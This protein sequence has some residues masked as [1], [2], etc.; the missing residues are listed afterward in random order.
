[1]SA[2]PSFEALDQAWA[3]MKRHPRLAL[4]ELDFKNGYFEE[5]EAYK[6]RVHANARAS[7]NSP[8]WRENMVGTGEIYQAAANAIKT[9]ENNLVYWEKRNDFS[10]E[11]KGLASKIEKA[12]W[13]IYKGGDSQESLKAGYDQLVEITDYQTTAFFFFL[14]EQ[15]QYLPISQDVFDRAFSFLGLDFKTSFNASWENYRHF[16]AI[17]KQV[18]AWLHERKAVTNRSALQDAHSFLYWL[19]VLVRDGHTKSFPE[20]ASSTAPSS[21]S[22]QEPQ[23]NE[24]ELPLFPPVG[25][26]DGTDDLD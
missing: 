19:G 15:N 21:T 26:T 8:R 4:A 12:L 23:P 14:K 24:T 16:I 6:Y 5:Q 2:L 20:V 11:Y 18:K 22:S 9:P 13:L 25:T 10:V 3:Y 17:H 7:L 1:M